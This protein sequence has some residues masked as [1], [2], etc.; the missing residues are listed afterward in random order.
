MADFPFVAQLR[1][2]SNFFVPR[3][4]VVAVVS[5]R[6]SDCTTIGPLGTPTMRDLIG[7]TLGHYRIVEKIVLPLFVA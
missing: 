6:F 3:E 2:N 7:Q 5:H 4:I 1:H